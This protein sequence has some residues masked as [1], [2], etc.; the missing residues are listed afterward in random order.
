[1]PKFTVGCDPEVVAID[2]V[3]GLAIPAWELTKG[4]KAKPIP[5]RG[6]AVGLKLQ[7]DGVAL[8]FNID[9]IHSLNE[10]IDTCTLFSSSIHTAM[11]E[12]RYTVKTDLCYE[13]YLRDKSFNPKAFTHPLANIR[14]CD[15]DF[16]AYGAYPEAPRII[17]DAAFKADTR[18]FGGH[19]H[20]GY[21]TTLAKPHIM[22]K[23]MDLFWYTQAICRGYQ[24]ERKNVYGQPGLYRPKPYGMEY[25]TPSPAWVGDRQ[26]AEHLISSIWFIV[27]ALE[28]HRD[29]LVKVYKDTDWGR[30]QTALMD[31][32]RDESVVLGRMAVMKFNRLTGIEDIDA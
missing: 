1:M 27:N 12:I 31:E 30:V 14:G 18:M 20:I 29:E 19:I 3:T 17:E 24:G 2:K 16:S 32:D 28:N 9:P 25:R 26:D 13:P 23:L 5:V 11:Q 22:A 8:E 15:P 10:A 7:A 4:T 6:S 21:D